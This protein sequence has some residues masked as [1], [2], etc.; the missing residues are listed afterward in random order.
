MGGIDLI[1]LNLRRQLTSHIDFHHRLK[2]PLYEDLTVGVA[3]IS[4]DE[5]E[6]D[7]EGGTICL[8]I[9]NPLK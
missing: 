5:T 2:L 6:W 4:V 9:L 3:I 8:D 1:H 7:E